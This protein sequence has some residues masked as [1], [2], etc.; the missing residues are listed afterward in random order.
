MKGLDVFRWLMPAGLA[1][2][3][4]VPVQTVKAHTMGGVC[5]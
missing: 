2:A 3:L 1:A 4:S 5:T